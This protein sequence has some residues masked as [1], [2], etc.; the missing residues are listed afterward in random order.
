MLSK[1]SVET[2]RATLP[3][4]GDAIGEIT[5]LFYDS[6]FTDHPELLR[7]LFNRGNQANGAQR[8]ALA[9][10][11]ATYAAALVT[12]H[13]T[14][15]DARLDTRADTMLNRIAHKHASLGVTREQYQLVHTHLFTAIAT[16]LG[17]SVTPEV[18][19]A[20]DEV[21]WLL[22]D[23]LTEIETRLYQQAGAT[24]GHTWREYRVIGRHTETHDVATFLVSPLDAAPV[25][26]FQPGQY[27]SVQVQ[28]P[29]GARQIRQYSL[30]GTACDALQF[31]V[32]RLT[33][34][35]EGEVS[36][37]LHDTVAEGDTVRVSAPF[38][39]VTLDHHDNPI[40]LAS[41]G[42]G[43]TPMIS[44]LRH[45]AKTGSN[46]HVIAVH[47]DRAPTTHAFRADLDLLAAK[48]PNAQ[49]HVWYETPH[50]PWP[51]DRTGH[52]DLTTLAIPADT[53]AYLCGP[54]PF[55]DTARDQL[56]TLGI[57][58]TRIRYELFGPDRLVSR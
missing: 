23:S 24:E 29:D 54:R 30:S 27:V 17:E 16:V 32:K 2:I 45:L 56:L 21:Y 36:N 55:M 52:S 48:L 41:A 34:A 26:T 15:P 31:T 13:D 12:H 6:L 33:G 1:K 25:P 19:A 53:T 28:L 44:M 46:R 50:V 18:A 5:T 9:A 4:V 58:T 14:Q 11:I 35:P 8:D 40:L 38:G 39:D 49:T 37:Y 51:T 42:I 20:W 7:D 3:A 43:C 22:A 10:A 47:A 57:P